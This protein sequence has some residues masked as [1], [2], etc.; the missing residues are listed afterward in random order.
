MISWILIGLS[1]TFLISALFYPAIRYQGRAKALGVHIPLL[2]VFRLRKYRIMTDDILQATALIKQHG[3]SVT[4]DELENHKL[5]RG[6]PLSVIEEMVESRK[7]GKDLEFK[8]A[9]AFDLAGKELRR[10]WKNMD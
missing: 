9:A 1:I 2:K 8:T 4:I 10:L 6:R 7:Q 3:L 5:A